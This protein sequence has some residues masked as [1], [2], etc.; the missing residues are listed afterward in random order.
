MSIDVLPSYV[1]IFHVAATVLQESQEFLR[2]RGRRRLEG[3][4]L[5]AGEPGDGGSVR[6]TRLIVPEQLAESTEFGSYV[7]LTRRAHY[8]LPDMLAPGELF[9]SRIHSHPGRAYHSSTDDANRVITHRGA[10]SIVVPDFA[11]APLE[12]SRCAIYFLEHG[13]GWVPFTPVQIGLHF[14]VEALAGAR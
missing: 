6:I 13:L 7:E 11:R 12:L 1:P 8:T 3:T 14:R 2:D 5:W 9:Y 10:I 4:A